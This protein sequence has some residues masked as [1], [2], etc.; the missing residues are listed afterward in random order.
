M[1]I[2]TMADVCITY[3]MIDPYGEREANPL[4]KWGIQNLGKWTLILSGIIES[5]IGLTLL[6]KFKNWITLSIL[7]IW[8]YLHWIGFLSWQPQTF[9]TLH[10]IGFIGILAAYLLYSIPII[11]ILIVIFMREYPLKSGRLFNYN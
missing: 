4:A 5:L 7:L 3:L 11:I 2:S 10:S 9:K 8:G 1:I 6:Y